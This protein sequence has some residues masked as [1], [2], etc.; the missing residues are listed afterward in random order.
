MHLRLEQKEAFL[1]PEQPW[2]EVLPSPLSETTHQRT[3]AGHGTGPPLRQGWRF[4]PRSTGE[5]ERSTG[6]EER[7]GVG[8]G[9][10]GHGQR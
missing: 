7:S 6:E 10:P 9:E 4:G 2:E 1:S 5:E 8:V 3:P